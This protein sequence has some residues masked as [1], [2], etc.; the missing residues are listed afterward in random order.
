M[1]GGSD[2]PDSDI[3][4][5]WKRHKTRGFADRKPLF[6]IGGKPLRNRVGD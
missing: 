4:A 5:F 2:N 1:K 3:T 6:K